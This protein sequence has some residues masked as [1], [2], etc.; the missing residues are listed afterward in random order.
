[1][2]PQDPQSPLNDQSAASQPGADLNAQIPP[3]Y[4]PG[5]A[6]APSTGSPLQDAVNAQLNS[7]PMVDSAAPAPVAAP[8]S[9]VAPA[10]P[11]AAAV[12]AHI[13]EPE[14]NPMAGFTD[15]V[16]AAAPVAP[17]VPAVAPAS[18]DTVPVAP[19]PIAP[20]PAPIAPAPMPTQAYDPSQ[21]V[22][23]GA[24]ASSYPSA[25][26]PLPPNPLEMDAATAPP[27]PF[28]P[29]QPI[30]AIPVAVPAPMPEPAP[31]AAPMAP[32]PMPVAPAMPEPAPVA[33]ESAFGQQFVDPA[34]G[35]GM[36]PGVA[37]PVDP[38]MAATDPTLQSMLD[39]PAANP[40]VGVDPYS[41]PALMAAASSSSGKAKGGKG[42]FMAVGIG[43]AVLIFGIIVLALILGRKPTTEV[44]AD[45]LSGD[46]EQSQSTSTEPTI[47]VPEGYTAIVKECYEFGL[48]TDNT[49]PT[50]DIS[51]KLD[52]TFG[53][54]G[55]STIAVLPSITAYEDLEKAVVASKEANKI[56]TANTVSERQI[57]L[58][59][60]DATEVVFN[61]GT[62]EAP[63]NKTM[64]VVVLKESKY[65]LDGEKITSFEIN[66][67]STDE[68]TKAAVSTLESTWSWK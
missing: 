42:I 16:V 46:Q 34:A 56:T 18:M 64:I 14:P 1:M 30:A 43:A 32:E 3:T 5:A 22:G 33:S 54:Q 2:T 23:V 61:A 26:E 19:Q 8:T 60:F 39:D 52:A 29:E 66:M 49:V 35:A 9:V 24:P 6:A 44:P 45:S 65:K 53:A 41:D 11:A 62:T 50:D 51:C 58:G 36:A 4:A 20:E 37:A 68:F 57:T 15:P 10:D 25:P 13:A 59:G 67:T 40:A 12:E 55:V 7:A 38:A 27:A 47:T 63:Q 17:V 48:P 21:D 31:T 28:L